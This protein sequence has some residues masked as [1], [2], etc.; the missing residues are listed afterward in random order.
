[1]EQQARSGLSLRELGKRAGTSHATLHAY[2]KGLKS[3]SMRTLSRILNACDFA[4]D[5]SLRRRIRQNHGLAR[6]DELVEVLKLAA[7]SQPGSQIS[8]K[9]VAS[10]PYSH[11]ANHFELDTWT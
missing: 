5:F 3:P 4:L 9:K 10:Y 11:R 8:L 6:G 2:I 7:S 1:M